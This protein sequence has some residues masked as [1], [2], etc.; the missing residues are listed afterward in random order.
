MFTIALF[1][2]PVGEGQDAI[3]KG[4]L[5]FGIQEHADAVRRVE[6]YLTDF[7]AKG[8]NRERDYWWCR[9]EGDPVTTIL[10]IAPDTPS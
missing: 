5:G 2:R 7:T 1:E 6:A 10:L 8:W 3:R 4:A 9:D